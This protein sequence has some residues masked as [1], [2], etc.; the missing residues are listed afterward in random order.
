MLEKFARAFVREKPGS[1]FCREGVQVVGWHGPAST[2]PGVS[3]VRGKKLL[4][5]YDVAEWLD[6]IAETGKGPVGIDFL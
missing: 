6:T 2:T 4:G 1:W 3:Y 5:P